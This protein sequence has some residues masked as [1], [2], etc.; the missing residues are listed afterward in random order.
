VERACFISRVRP[1]RLAMAQTG[2]NDRWQAEMKEFF[3]EDTDQRP[4]EGFRRLPEI[5]AST[6]SR[7]AFLSGDDLNA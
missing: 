6:D 3:A 5:S 2:V 4:D 1:D 7:A